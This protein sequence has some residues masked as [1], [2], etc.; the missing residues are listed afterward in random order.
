METL[1]SK[2]FDPFLFK[3]KPI[4]IFQLLKEFSDCFYVTVSTFCV[5]PTQKGPKLLPGSEG[6]RF[7]VFSLNAGTHFL[8]KTQ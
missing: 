2:H 8:G 1:L 4:K 7:E 6:T 5:S 3:K